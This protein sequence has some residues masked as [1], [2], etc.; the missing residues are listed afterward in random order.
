MSGHSRDKDWRSVRPNDETCNGLRAGGKPVS[1]FR[2]VRQNA[3]GIDRASRR[4]FEDDPPDGAGATPAL[5]P[6]PQALMNPARAERLFARR[7]RHEPYLTVAQYI[8]RAD[9]H[10]LVSRFRSLL[11]FA[12]RSDANF[13]IEGHQQ[14]YHASAALNPKFAIGLAAIVVRTSGSRH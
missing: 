9:D 12:A 2:L 7:G 6:T 3:T 5:H 4:G 10:S 13:G 1:T 8:A 11:N 14:I